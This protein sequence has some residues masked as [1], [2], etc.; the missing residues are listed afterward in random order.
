MC[1]SFRY[2]PIDG[3][4]GDMYWYADKEIVPK[5]VQYMECMVPQDPAAECTAAGFVD[6]TVTNSPDTM[7][8]TEAFFNG[9]LVKDAAF[10][11]ADSFFR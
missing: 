1:Y 7:I 11:A 6:C 8:Q 9:S 2:R 4:Y 3:S 5:S 10:R